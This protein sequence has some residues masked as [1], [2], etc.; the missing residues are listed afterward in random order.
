MA[1]FEWKDEFRTGIESIDAEHRW[2]M[3][4]VNDFDDK[5]R[6]EEVDAASKLF[7]NIKDY[8]QEHSKNEENLMIR[9]NY[10][11]YA[12]HSANHKKI[13]LI[14]F[15]LEDRYR[16]NGVISSA[17]IKGFIIDYFYR[18]IMVDDKKF[19]EFVKS[20]GRE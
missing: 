2:L 4:S 14:A 10:P 7:E 17:E 16:R 9:Y 13:A 5:C 3:D 20:A 6:K 12:A 11:D 8:L 1:I 19:G 15:D 18:H